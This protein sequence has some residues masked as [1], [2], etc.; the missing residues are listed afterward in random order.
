[1]RRAALP[2]LLFTWCAL[3]GAH[4]APNST[5]RLEFG[6]QAVRAEYWVPVSE[7]A[8]ARAADAGGDFTAYLMRHLSAQTPQGTAWQ[9]AVD[10]VREDRYL[11]HDFLVARLTLRPPPGSTVQAF[12]LL[13]DAVTHEV[14]NHVVF[15]VARHGDEAEMVGALQYPQRRLAIAPR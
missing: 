1:M 3:A 11:D 5:L 6:A 10:A 8:Y 9:V 13:D 4:P 7:L 15:V 12:V 14:R 2:V